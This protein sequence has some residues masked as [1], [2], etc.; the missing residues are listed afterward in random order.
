MTVGLPGSG[1]GGIFYLLSALAMPFHA[2]GEMALGALGVL[3]ASSR[4][5]QPWGLIWRQ[6][7]LAVGIIAGLWGTG[8]LIA[9]FLASHPTALGQ[10]Q[11]TEIGR[12]LPNVLRTG[13]ILVSLVTLGAV[14]LAVQI[15][16]LVVSSQA[17]EIRY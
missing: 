4:R 5:S 9:A 16:R 10:A 11:T 17:R 8:W 1:I 6:F 13:A 14:L 2:L 7:G 15:A 12:R 3:P